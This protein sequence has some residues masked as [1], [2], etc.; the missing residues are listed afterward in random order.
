MPALIREDYD[1]R[2]MIRN[3]FFAAMVSWVGIERA[4][5]YLRINIHTARP[6]VVIGKKGAD[7]E[8]LRTEIET[9]TGHK[10]FINVVEIKTPEMDPRLVAESIALQLEKRVHFGSALKRAMDRTM[11]SGALGIKIMVSGRLGGAEIARRERKREGR[12]PLHTFC[13]DIDYGFVEAMTNMGKIGVKV[14]IFKKLLFAK[15]P[16]ELLAELRKNSGEELVLSQGP[17][18]PEQPAAVE[19][20]K[21]K[22]TDLNADAKESKRP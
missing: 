19:R 22:E 12:I 20:E 14:W 21:K 4:G 15:T 7:I 16:K 8:G 3:R 2:R 6:G 18:K 5:S 17:A 13:A 10:S 9:L 11:T 1:I